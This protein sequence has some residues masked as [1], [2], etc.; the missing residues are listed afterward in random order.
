MI[1]AKRK[2]S[3]NT[4]AAT[5]DGSERLSSTE[6]ARRPCSCLASRRRSSRGLHE[7]AHGSA[8]VDLKLPRST[9][10]RILGLGAQRKP[11]RAPLRRRRPRPVALMRLES[12]SYLL[13]RTLNLEIAVAA[14]SDNRLW[15]G[16]EP[17]GEAHSAAGEAADVATHVTR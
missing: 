7:S 5:P 15:I 4:T 11:T 14:A 2:G 10:R 12:C 6:L 9:R 13:A 3:V 1:P 16:Q 17:G 8:R